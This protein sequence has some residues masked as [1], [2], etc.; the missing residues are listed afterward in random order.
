M[1]WLGYTFCRGRLF[2]TVEQD[3]G[4]YDKAET[5]WWTSGAAMMIR[6]ELYHRLDGLD[7]KFFAHMEEIDL[8]WRLKRAGY[9]LMVEPRSVVY[10]VGGGSLPHGNPH[11]AFLNFRNSLYM[12]VKNMPVG[13]LLWFLPFR[14]MLDW[15]AGLKALLSGHAG[16]S[17]AIVKAHLAFLARPG[18][19]V[20]MR[21]TAARQ[22]KESR[23]GP[24]NHSGLYRGSLLWDYF[25]R[26]KRIFSQLPSGRFIR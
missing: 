4:Q 11:K 17:G 23:T 2:D 20:R 15:V 3:T 22:V 9:R 12:F 26:K 7:E 19:C 6:A 21:R 14:L 1:D 8:C 18:R 5:V 25:V 13:R 10:H 24:T 16:E